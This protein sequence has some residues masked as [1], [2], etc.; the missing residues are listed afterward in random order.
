VD[1]GEDLVKSL[2]L[3]TLVDHLDRMLSTAVVPDYETA[4]NG[5]QFANS[6]HVRAI[7]AAVDASRET[8]RGAAEAGASLLL[9]HHGLFWGG[10]QP[11]RGARYE[12]YRELF[13]HDLAV[14]SS[15]LP[16]DL[17]P[18]FGNNVL[19]AKRFGLTPAL[20]FAA[21]KGVHIGVAGDAEIATAELLAIADALAR[22]H[23]GAARSS[24]VQPGRLTRR[25]AICSG[26]GASASTLAEARAMG[27]DTLIVGEGAHWTAVD[28]PEQELVIIYAGHYATETLGIAE[29]ARRVAEEFG[30]P[31]SFI[32]APTGL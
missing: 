30:V 25:W 17:H 13:A 23:A 6:G 14:Y 22:E 5:L 18:V 11:V 24:A 9:V 32:A 21:F 12:R 4:L 27:I 15:H 26:G 10:L 29:L 1:V 7:A 19:L 16:L 3:Q 8:I 31:W 20:P 2:A 28:A